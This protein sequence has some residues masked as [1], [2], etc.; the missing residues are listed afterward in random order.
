MRGYA[1]E[2]TLSGWISVRVLS[3]VYL[4]LTNL[5]LERL[6]RQDPVVDLEQGSFSESGEHRNSVLR[7]H[8]QG[9]SV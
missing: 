1:I 6:T 8:H 9:Q 4:L 5:S 2:G 3:I 7:I